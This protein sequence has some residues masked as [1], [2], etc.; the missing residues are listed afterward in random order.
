MAASSTMS[1]GGPVLSVSDLT[2]PLPPRADRPYAV[3]SVSFQVEK[4]ETVC[5]LGE[6][7]SGKSMIASS[8]MGLL[9]SGLRPSV[10]SIKLEGREL[11]GLTQNGL[12]TLRGPSMAMVF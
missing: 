3:E 5:L 10:G 9:P 6:S 12:R 8:I 2:I 7:G 1:I 4:S 11:V